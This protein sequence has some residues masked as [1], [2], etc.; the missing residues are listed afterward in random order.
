MRFVV[1][2]SGWRS[3]FHLRVA[4]AAPDRLQV[5]GVVTQS[6]AEGER[7][8]RGG[9]YPV[10]RASPT[11]WRSG[12]SSSWQPCR[13]RRCRTWCASSSPPGSDV[14]AETPPA[15]DLEGLRSLWQDVGESGLVQVGEQYALMPGHASRLA[16]V[17]EGVI[18][19]A[20]SVEVASTHLY[21]AVSLVRAFLDVDMDD[22]TV[23][24]RTFQAP[25]ADP[26]TFDG[27]VT[28][29]QPS[30]RT[31]TIATLDFGDG[32]MGLYDFVDNQWWNPLRRRRIVVRGSLGEIVDD[33]VT[34]LTPAGPRHLADRLPPHRGRHEP[35][36]QRRRARL[37]RRTRRVHATRGSA[38]GSP[39]T[40]SPSPSHLVAT[41]DGRAVRAR[42][43]PARA[44][45]PG[46]RAG[47]GD[48]RVRAYRRRRARRQG[49]V[50]RP[51]ALTAAAGRGPEARGA[52]RPHDD[53]GQ[54]RGTQMGQLEGALAVVTGGS[55]GIGGRSRSGSWPRART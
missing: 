32:R 49:A 44:S 52:G 33:T 55:Q 37:V 18:G 6:A 30:P 28:D 8:T 45:L 12:R 31:T 41:G 54:G 11:R 53:M 4:Q 10:W 14:L 20:T 17:R 35:R 50:G 13:G 40:T 48:R 47:P 19:A 43:L 15:P 25:L 7:I 22:T 3:E 26:L 5:V 36:G 34:R 39:R 16:V 46:P 38:P 21:H 9:V 27:W 24:A 51:G 23:T 29:P 1:I 42:A 2:G